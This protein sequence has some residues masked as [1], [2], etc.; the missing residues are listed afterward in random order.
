MAGTILWFN[1]NDANIKNLGEVLLIVRAGSDISRS[2]FI[3][4]REAL[5]VPK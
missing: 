1:A 2:D 3:H 5:V 4:K